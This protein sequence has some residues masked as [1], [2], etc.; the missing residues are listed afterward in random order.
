[1]GKLDLPRKKYSL[2]SCSMESFKVVMHAFFVSICV[3]QICTARNEITLE[4][5]WLSKSLSR[6]GKRILADQVGWNVWGSAPIYGGD[7]KVHVFFSRWRG[8]HSNWLVSSEIAHAV[9]NHPEGPYNVLG[10]ALKGRGEGYWDADTIHNPNIQK[11]DQ[12]YALTYIGNNNSKGKLN[13]QKIGIAVADSLY[14]PWRRISDEPVINVSANPRN[15]DEYCVVNPSLIRHPNGQYW[16]YY[17]A[18]DR[19][20]DNM[21]KA[22]LAT[23]DSLE[24]PYIKYKYNPILNNQRYKANAQSEDP[25][26]FYYNNQFHAIVKDMGLQNYLSGLYHVSDDGLNWSYPQLAY[27]TSDNYFDGERKRFER[28]QILM[29]NGKPDYLFLAFMGGKHISSGAV[30]KIN[31]PKQDRIPEGT[32]EPRIT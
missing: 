27:N 26:M 25:Y 15:W 21:R 17:R 1:M 9:A 28:P 31:L 8:N 6:K 14:G 12:R 32:Q 4:E 24:G 16:M 11:I 7:G 18:W 29:K 23:A 13:S 19:N 30:L 22:G 5:S 2:P 20:N 3:A 10:T